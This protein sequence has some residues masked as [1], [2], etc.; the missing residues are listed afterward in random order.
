MYYKETGLP[1]NSWNDVEKHVK[2]G[3]MYPDFNYKSRYGFPLNEINIMVRGE[4]YRVLAMAVDSGQEGDIRNGDMT[5]PGRLVLL[6]RPESDF[7]V[8][9]MKEKVLFRLFRESGY[10]PDDYT[11]KNAQW[12]NR[13]ELENDGIH[14]LDGESAM[15]ESSR[16][17]DEGPAPQEKRL[18]AK[19]EKSWSPQ[20]WVIAVVALAT[21]LIFIFKK[22]S[23]IR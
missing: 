11:G 8:T 4:R 18:H 2:V 22:R 6:Y 12:A 3:L 21:T 7:L 5:E 16:K 14:G 19:T 10:N 20:I 13:N 9:R 17:S 1:P 15:D 23:S